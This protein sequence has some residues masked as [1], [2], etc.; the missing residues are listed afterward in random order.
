MAVAKGL[1]EHT[2][3]ALTA[4]RGVESTRT[5]QTPN[6]AT[7]ATEVS[8]IRELSGQPDA[9]SSTLPLGMRIEITEVRRCRVCVPW[10][11]GTARVT[12]SLLS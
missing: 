9:F 12:V 2:L 5:V 11:A 4:W 10:S 6:F 7:L 8:T 1:T 3:P